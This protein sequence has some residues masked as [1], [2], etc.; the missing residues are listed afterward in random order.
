[1]INNTAEP[2]ANNFATLLEQ[3]GIKIKS[4]HA[5]S[6]FCAALLEDGRAY[7]WGLND[8]G[9]LGIGQSI[10]MDMY[11]SEKYPNLV[12]HDLEGKEVSE[13]QV[14]ETGCMF[15]TGDNE[16]FMSGLKTWWSPSAKV[17]PEGEVITSMFTGNKF[18]GVVT[19]NKKVYALRYPFSKKEVTEL[20]DL[21]MWK[22]NEDV[23][24]DLQVHDIGGGHRN[25][26]ALLS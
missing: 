22:I 20:I 26:Y 15:K 10:G 9:Q 18:T 4:I 3:E 21:G 2:Q 5:C 23:F 16:F 11:E 13:I 7:T 24:H 12:L 1:M 14:G 19:D 8:H 6:N 25:H 17:L